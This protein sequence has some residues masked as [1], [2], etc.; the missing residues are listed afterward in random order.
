MGIGSNMKKM[1]RNLARA[2]N[3][4][5]SSKVPMKFADGG[6]V[7]AAKDMGSYAGKG[8][9]G[10]GFGKGKAR[11]GGAAKKGTGFRGSF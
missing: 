9:D 1:G 8:M 2:K 6:A 5:G 3:Q 7:P 4:S 10:S 11:G